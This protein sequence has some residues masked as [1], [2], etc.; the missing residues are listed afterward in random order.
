[1]PE[2]DYTQFG[3]FLTMCVGLVLILRTI[4]KG[5]GGNGDKDASTVNTPAIREIKTLV[6]LTSKN[7]DSLATNLKDHRTEVLDELGRQRKVMGKLFDQ[8][9]ATNLRVSEVDSRVARVEGRLSAK[10]GK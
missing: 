10:G 4:I 6:E 1:M 5:R 7:V 8:D 2:I 3:M 9:S